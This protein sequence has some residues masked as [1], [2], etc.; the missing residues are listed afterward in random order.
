[1][2]YYQNKLQCEVVYFHLRNEDEAFNSYIFQSQRTCPML[3]CQDTLLDRLGSILK[4]Q[5]F[6]RLGSQLCFPTQP[7]AMH[8]YL[9]LVGTLSS[10]SLHLWKTINEIINCSSCVTRALKYGITDTLK[11]WSKLFRPITGE[12]SVSFEIIGIC[13]FSAVPS[14]D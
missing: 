9:C 7:L 11:L 2:Q 12:E 10:S 4:D 3:L 5:P 13:T 6:G 1:M 8:L 14:P